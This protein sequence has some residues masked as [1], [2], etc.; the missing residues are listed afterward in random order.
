MESFKTIKGKKANK[1]KKLRINK[2]F[3]LDSTPINQLIRE[4]NIFAH[5]ICEHNLNLNKSWYSKLVP[6]IIQEFLISSEIK[7]LD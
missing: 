2:Y 1:R 4:N 7:N 6:L 3:S 5:E